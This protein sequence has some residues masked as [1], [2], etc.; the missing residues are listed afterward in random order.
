[1]GLSQLKDSLCYLMRLWLTAAAAPYQ[2][3]LVPHIPWDFS[4]SLDFIFVVGLLEPLT[5]HEE[6]WLL[7]PALLLTHRVTVG[8]DFRHPRHGCKLEIM[9]GWG[10]LE[11]WG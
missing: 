3:Q 1:M 9:P 5:W 10:C 6:L 4:G 7:F 11:T 8:G 2:D